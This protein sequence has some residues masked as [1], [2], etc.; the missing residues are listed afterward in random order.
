MTL[1]ASLEL[2]P[3]GTNAPDV[4]VRFTL[5][6]P[7]SETALIEREITPELVGTTRQAIAELP[8]D[9]LQAGSYVIH[10]TVVEAGSVT[11]SVTA[12][13]RKAQ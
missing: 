2:Y 9:D 13:I 7:G 4:V 5:T 1:G 8:V 10:A 11:G 3:D 6:A 12:T